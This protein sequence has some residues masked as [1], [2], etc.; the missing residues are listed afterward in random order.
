LKFN[1]K[2]SYNNDDDDELY[3][4]T[5]KSKGSLSKNKRKYMIYHLNFQ[6]SLQVLQIQ[7][8]TKRK[9]KSVKK[10]KITYETNLTIE[11]NDQSVKIKHELS[12]D[13]LF[14]IKTAKLND[15][16]HTIQ[17]FYQYSYYNSK[18]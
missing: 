17:L 15:D 12:Y 14:A 16:Q 2:I 13:K 8:I 5:F 3:F 6:S 11:I 1:N 4:G 10:I 7:H 18:L 9:K